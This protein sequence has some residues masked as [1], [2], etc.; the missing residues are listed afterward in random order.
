MAPAPE[1][2]GMGS[3]VNL[4]HA[5]SLVI[6]SFLAIA[7]YN[8]AELTVLIHTF[9][10][11]RSSFYYYALLVATWGIFLHGLG[12]CFKFYRITNSNILNTVLAYTGWIMMVTGQSIVLYSRLHLLIQARWIRWVLAM[13]ILN[14][15]V[16]HTSTGVLTFLTNLSQDSQ[17]WKSEYS[18]V[19]RVQVTIFFVQE[20]I[21][22]AI[23]IW[24]TSMM[25]RA[26]GPLFNARQNARGDL[27][28][29]V[30][31]N[32]ILINVFIICL[33]ITLVALEFSGCE[34]ASRVAVMPMLTFS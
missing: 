24:K 32:T 33:E 17:V 8:V 30:L 19:E 9:F 4:P 31:V 2:S 6:A 7:W 15:I 22:S 18:V 23:Y 26:E 27:G 10:K 13:I 21:L 12:M 29:R 25:L 3:E 14:A 1:D 34:S 11:R 28:R 16:L 5:N 20:L